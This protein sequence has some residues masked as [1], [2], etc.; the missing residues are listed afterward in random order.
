VY[1][2]LSTSGRLV[3]LGVAWTQIAGLLVA[4]LSLGGALPL[5]EA[6]ALGLP[7]GAFYAWH[8]LAL[9]YLA[10]AVPVRDTGPLRLLATHS[11]VA[12][13]TASV[14]TAVG[15]GLV[16][17]LSRVGFPA[18]PAGV[19]GPFA[20]SPAVAYARA[21]PIVLGVGVL[22]TLL[23]LALHYLILEL[24]ASR[25]AQTQALELQ[26]H[27]RD[28]EVKALRAQ[29]QPHF[30]YNALNSINSLIGSDPKAARRT[31]VQLGDLLRR[32][33][34]LGPKDSIPLSQELELVEALLQ[35]EKVRFGDRL[36]YR[37]DVG[38]DARER[39]VPPLL[40]QPL[41]E[42]AVTHGIAGMLD[43]G[44]VQVGGALESD[45]LR[46]W[47]E[48]PRDPDSGS[49]RGTGIGLENVRRRVQALFGREGAV[50]VESGE[51]S[52]RVEVVLPVETAED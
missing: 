21:T 49:R 17:L 18:P 3:V 44:T 8:G 10:R 24:E 29:L 28:A 9:Y 7:I 11:L 52:F 40:L 30:L 12:I 35:I 36:E 39:A 46:L 20:P 6:L 43:G 51:T 50:H 4:L 14:W 42:N 34:S 48:N 45:Q 27:S 38:E 5:R 2:T 32:I 33:L 13:L 19:A 47:V 26:L 23:A 1:P 41:V 37:V 15:R 25:A 22:L 16:E 31:C